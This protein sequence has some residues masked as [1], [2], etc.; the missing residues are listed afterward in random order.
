MGDPFDSPACLIFDIEKYEHLI[1]VTQVVHGEP[2]LLHTCQGTCVD[3]FAGAGDQTQSQDLY[4]TMVFLMWEVAKQ[5]QLRV[6]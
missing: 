2:S 5:L 4:K 3:I 1:S 6:R